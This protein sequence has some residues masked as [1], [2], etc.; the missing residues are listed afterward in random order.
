VNNILTIGHQYLMVRA[1]RAKEAAATG[2][3]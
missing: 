1:D 3:I 2:G